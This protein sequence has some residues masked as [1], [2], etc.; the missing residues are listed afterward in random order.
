[1]KA[2]VPAAGFGRR[3]G[4]LT[5]S[6]PK[7]LL[8]VGGVPLIY[9]TL[10]HL[11][12]WKISEVMINLHY[13][14]DDLRKELDAFPHLRLSYSFEP[15][16]LGTAGGLRKVR[17]WMDDDWL[18][19]LNPDTILLPEP[20]MHPLN[21]SQGFDTD[22]RTYLGL[23]ARNERVETGL[24]MDGARRLQFATNGKLFYMGYS[25]V[26]GE[27]FERLQEDE[28]AELG[29]LWRIQAEKNELRGFLYRGEM[30]D[31]GNEEAFF[32]I[33]AKIFPQD[34]GSEFENFIRFRGER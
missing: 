20:E 18:L 10:F 4:S 3:M 33:P 34:T 31:A 26:R 13:R 28:Y 7:P 12:R 24:E 23:A 22:A 8:S 29:P 25:F 32:A 2:F 21:L 6:C 19:V 1:V 9:Y 17:N 27:S 5:L 16:I 14:A 11:F 15:T 30:I